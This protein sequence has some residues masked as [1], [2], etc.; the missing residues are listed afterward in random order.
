MKSMYLRCY[1]PDPCV[2]L[3]LKRQRLFAGCRTFA[4]EE[5]CAH[6]GAGTGMCF[7][8]VDWRDDEDVQLTF[9][10]GCRIAQTMLTIGPIARPKALTF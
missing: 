6:W 1:R 8:Q 10:R 3:D 2:S 9:V 4:N 7:H 5:R